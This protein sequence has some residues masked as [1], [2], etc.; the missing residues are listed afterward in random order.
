MNIFT[1]CCEPNITDL[2]LLPS[3]AFNDEESNKKKTRNKRKKKKRFMRE[4]RK[5]K[6]IRHVSVVFSSSNFV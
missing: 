5:K 6:T 1:K 3:V 2:R 4:E